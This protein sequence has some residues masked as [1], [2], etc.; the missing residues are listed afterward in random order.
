MKTIPGKDREPIDQGGGI[1]AGCG[2]GGGGR[3]YQVRTWSL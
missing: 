3:P 1:Q 2:G